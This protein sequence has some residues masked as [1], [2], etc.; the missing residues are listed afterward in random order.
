MKNCYDSKYD[1]LCGK[2]QHVI[3]KYVTITRVI[4]ITAI[5]PNQIINDTDTN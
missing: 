3:R 5:F 4:K 2:G 1:S